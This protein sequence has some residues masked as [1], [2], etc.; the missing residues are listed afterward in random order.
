[1]TFAELK[2]KL[3]D[4][5]NRDDLS[6]VTG[7]LINMAMHIL[8]RGIFQR[9]DGA[10]MKHS[11]RCMKARTTT[12]LVSGTHTVTNPFPRYKEMIN[13]HIMDTTNYRYP[14]LQRESYDYALALYPN[15]TEATGRPLI[16]TEAP[17]VESSLTP[18]IAPTLNILL[19]P[20]S[21]ASYTLDMTAYQYSPDLDGIT[22]TTNWWTQN[23]WELLLYGALLQAEAYLVN[24]TRLP[25]WKAFY[26]NAV[27]HLVMAEKQEAQGHTGLNIKPYGI[28]PGQGLFNING[29]SGGY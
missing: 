25:V 21:D 29:W 12:A 5:L 7:D 6:S 16:F 8:E 18:D 28:G 17:A 11:F 2:T 10:L 27:S 26:D 23:A 15:L 24:D 14:A 22:Y 3:A 1:M 9:A 4:Y 19:R 13:A 20:T